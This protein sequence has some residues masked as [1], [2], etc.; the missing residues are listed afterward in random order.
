[1]T[2]FV[3]STATASTRFQGFGDTPPGG[4]HTVVRQVMVHGG[5]NIASI[6][7]GF[8]DMTADEQG[9]PMWTPKGTVTRVTDEDAKFL[10]E[11][12]TFQIGV[13]A[14]FYTILDTDPGQDHKKIAKIAAS[15]LKN[16]DKSAPL[17]NET[18]AQKVKVSTAK[19][20]E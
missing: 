14:G 9:I 13:N 7:S 10:E 3:L 15:E 16:A 8:G 12:P 19:A 17:T 4:V 18:L 6:K 20:E 1:M 5:N 11:H 2:K